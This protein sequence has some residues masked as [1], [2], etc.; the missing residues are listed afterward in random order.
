[1][2][3]SHKRLL[4]TKEEYHTFM[5][6]LGREAGGLH[7]YHSGDPRKYPCFA[8]TEM[9]DDGFSTPYWDHLFIYAED[10][11]HELGYKLLT[12]EERSLF[13]A[14]MIDGISRAPV[15]SVKDKKLS[16]EAE[17]N[18]F[19]DHIDDLKQK[20]EGSHGEK[21]DSNAPAP[22]AYPEKTSVH[23]EV[24]EVRFRQWEERRGI[25]V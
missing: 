24:Q 20:M 17:W 11:D 22:H 12:Q 8:V 4:V 3:E 23:R 19:W 21:K 6:F 13:K 7:L 14:Y 10:V 1:M 5:D 18:D 16:E 9:A 25:D 15:A 2:M